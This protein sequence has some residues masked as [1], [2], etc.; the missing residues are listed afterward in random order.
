MEPQL[1]LIEQSFDMRYSEWVREALNELPDCFTITDPCVSGHPVV[2]ASNGFLKMVGYSKD[3]VIGKNG[4]IFQGPETDRRSV[5]EI[6]EAIREERGV[7]ISLLNYRKDGTPF[8]MLFQMCPVF[9]KED[10]RVINFVGV[11][12]PILRKPRRLSGL[13]IVRNEMNLCEDGAGIR[14]SVFRCCRREV[15]SDSILELGRA[16][17]PE[18]VSSHDDRGV[19]INDPCEASELE[20]TKASAAISSIMSVLTHYSELTGRL[21]CRKRCCLTGNGQLGAS[22]NMSLG[23]IKQSFVLTDAL[24]PDMPIVYASEA[25]LKLTGYARHEVLG[26]NCRF[27]SGI[28]TDPTT[29]FQIKECIRTH[30]ACTVR[31]LNYRKDRTSFW[32]F[33]HISPVRNASGKVAFFVGIQIDDCCKNQETHGL[34]PEIRQLSVVGAVKVAVRSL[35]MGASTS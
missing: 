23:R 8:W 31:I 6:R 30:Q 22:L 26:Q 2:F 5:M 9:S 34:S 19:E 27:L 35:S 16:S 13:R 15:G 11:Q 18:L 1:G 21:V 33:L 28:D 10:G 3:E 17:A 29:Q 32:N 25:F 20:K 14:E 24:L 4:R 12:V 7:Q